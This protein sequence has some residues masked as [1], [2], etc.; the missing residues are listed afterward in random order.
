MTMNDELFKAASSRFLLEPEALTSDDLDVLTRVDPVLGECA[1]KR[2]SEMLQKSAEARHRAALGQPPVVLKGFDVD[3]V[4]DATLAV[5]T[6]YLAKPRQR[7]RALEA[8]NA[9]LA[10]RCFA[11]EQR[12]LE[13]EAQRAISHVDG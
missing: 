10:E 6:L 4:A 13:L 12:M 1:T 11:L 7:I 3:S 9:A 5:I 8:Q 2:R